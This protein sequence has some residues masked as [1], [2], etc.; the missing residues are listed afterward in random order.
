MRAENLET[1]VMRK[2]ASNKRRGVFLRADFGGL[3]EYD[4]VGRALRLLVRKGKLV[5]IGQGLY[6]KAAQSPF[7]GSPA[8]VKGLRAL[9]AEALNRLGVK[10]GPTRFEK[11]YNAGGTTQVPSGRILAVNKRV[12]RKI[13]YNG[14]YVSFE[15]V[16]QSPKSGE[17]KG[18]GGQGGQRKQRKPSGVNRQG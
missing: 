9:A 15:R 14:A 17:H 12:R 13:G 7:D 2:V 3:G 4:Q 5:K 8:P 16:S 1:R 6:A 11:A 18:R 10:S